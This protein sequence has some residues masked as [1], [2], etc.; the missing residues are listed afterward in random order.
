M[1]RRL[2]GEEGSQLIEFLW[3]LPMSALLVLAIWQF[4]LAG[5]A[6]IV[7]VNAAMEGAHALAAG[8]NY[9]A[10]V[11]AASDGMESRASCHSDG[12]RASC[13]VNLL[14]P[15]VPLPVVAGARMWTVA[16]AVV[17]VGS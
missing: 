3:L 16:S 2:G 1:R 15:T 7:T 17:E 5:Y 9:G 10:A 4:M 8:Q 11:A 12:V 13:R 14:I 6:E